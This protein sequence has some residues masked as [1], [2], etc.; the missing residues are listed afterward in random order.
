MFFP[1]AS[2]LQFSAVCPTIS[3]TGLKQCE[4]IAARPALILRTRMFLMLLS[5]SIG[6]NIILSSGRLKEMA[7]IID[8]PHQCHVT[9][10][11][12]GAMRS[13]CICSLQNAR[14]AGNLICN[15]CYWR[16]FERIA[17]KQFLTS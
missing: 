2:G 16:V 1:T 3:S 17:M 5:V 7:G 9:C 4:M 11:S 10:G 14:E 12:V 6:R 15:E 13:S 8:S